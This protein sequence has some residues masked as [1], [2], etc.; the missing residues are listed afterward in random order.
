MHEIGRWKNIILLAVVGLV[1]ACAQ[2]WTRL[3]VVTVGYA[4]SNTRQLLRTLEGQRQMLEAEWRAKTAPALLAEQATQRLGLNIP[5]P[6]QV[7]RVR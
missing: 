2:V 7:V 6:G 5:Q 3:Q 1:L 4:L